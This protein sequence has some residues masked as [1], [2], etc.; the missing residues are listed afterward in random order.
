MLRLVICVKSCPSA[1]HLRVCVCADIE[2]HRS[3]TLVGH[4]LPAEVQ[5][6]LVPGQED[7]R[8]GLGGVHPDS[9]PRDRGRPSCSISVSSADFIHSADHV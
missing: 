5:E 8:A 4:L 7:H 2:C 9:G 1:D 3:G 6:H